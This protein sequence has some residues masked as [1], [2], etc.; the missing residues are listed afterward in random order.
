MRKA[1]ALCMVVALVAG[2]RTR[3]IDELPDAAPDGPPADLA[4]PDLVVGPCVRHRLLARP[5]TEMRLLNPGQLDPGQQRYGSVIRVLLGVPLAP[6]EAFGDV[7]VRVMPGNA[8]DLVV[9]TVRV[10]QSDVDCGAATTHYRVIQLT[11]E[12][13]LSSPTV[14]VGDGAPGATVVLKFPV[15]PPPRGAT[16]NSSVPPGGRCQLDCQCRNDAATSRCILDAPDSGLCSFPCEEDA[17][18]PMGRRCATENDYTCV[19]ATG[20]CAMSCPFGQACL[21]A[22]ECRPVQLL[23]GGPCSCDA[24]CG[25]GRICNEVGNCTIPCTTDSDCWEDGCVEGI[26]PGPR[27]G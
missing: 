20:T 12:H 7:Q 24:D 26:C 14:V 16:C 22:G 8:T 11:S 21:G 25:A 15:L 9:A 18:C 10:W 3:P 6:C 27:G 1:G 13:G 23:F 19:K 17:D 4:Q 2:C 5:V